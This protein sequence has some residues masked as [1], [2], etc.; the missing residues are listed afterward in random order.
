[1]QVFLFAL[2]STL[3]YIFGFDIYY[4]RAWWNLAIHYYVCKYSV[5]NLII[6]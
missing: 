3:I 6:Q 1:M 2:L 4:Y 5:N